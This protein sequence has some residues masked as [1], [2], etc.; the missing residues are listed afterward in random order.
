MPP[1]EG[2]SLFY[3][4]FP[5]TTP[6][7]QTQS[8]YFDGSANPPAHMTFP[9]ACR[10]RR[11]STMRNVVLLT[12]IG[13]FLTGCAAKKPRARLPVAPLPP[14]LPQTDVVQIVAASEL[15]TSTAVL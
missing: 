7:N 4:F 13:V 11:Q 8:G 1:D 12:L 9:I 6:I 14:P 2:V 5:A 10:Q 15:R 3:L